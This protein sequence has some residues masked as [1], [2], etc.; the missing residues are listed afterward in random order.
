MKE[1]GN[2]D[3]QRGK[4]PKK[5]MRDPMRKPQREADTPLEGDIAERH[6][7]RRPGAPENPERQ[8]R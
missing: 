8:N 7:D 2:K 1:R 5:P 3:P 6:G 4:E